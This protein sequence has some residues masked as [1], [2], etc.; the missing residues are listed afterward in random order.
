MFQTSCQV[1]KQIKHSI[2]RRG[3]FDLITIFGEAVVNNIRHIVIGYS[4]S[5][6]MS[7]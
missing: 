5:Y 6:P 7:G 4:C 1:G 2:K 3:L